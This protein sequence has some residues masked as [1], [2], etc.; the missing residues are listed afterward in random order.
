[1]KKEEKMIKKFL[2]NNNNYESINKLN[3]NQIYKLFKKLYKK[4]DNE[5]N[6]FPYKSALK[7]DKRTYFQFYFSLLKSNHLL[8]FSFLPKFDFNSRI[9]KIYL[10]FFNFA[11]FFFVNALFFTDKTMGKINIDGGSFNLIYNLPQT[12]YSFIISSVINTIIMILTLS[13]TS[14]IT[15]RNK[16]KKEKILKSASNLKRNFKIKFIIFFILDFIFL[17]F[18]WIYLSCFSAVY[19]NTQIHLIK[20]TLI[21]F[22]TSLISPFASYLLPGIFRIYSLK[23]K[24]RR[25]WYTISQILQF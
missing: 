9:I 2:K 25:I 5:W 22:G 6:N 20:D 3:D 7:Y 19:H 24:K 1:M 10:F 13:Q 11:T 17:S 14:F 23:N 15:F 12:I 18:F 21:S 16:A 8:F 4:T